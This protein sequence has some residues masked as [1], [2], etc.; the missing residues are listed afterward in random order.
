[1]AKKGILVLMM[2]ALVMLVGVRKGQRCYIS[3]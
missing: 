1:M 2:L 3:S